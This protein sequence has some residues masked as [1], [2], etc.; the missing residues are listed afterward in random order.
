MPFGNTWVIY[1]GEHIAYA[2]TTLAREDS[3]P[4]VAKA[5][6]GYWILRG[7]SRRLGP[8][9]PYLFRNRRAMLLWLLLCR[10]WA[11]RWRSIEYMRLRHLSTVRN[12]QLSSIDKSYLYWVAIMDRPRLKCLFPT[13]AIVI[14]V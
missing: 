4:A 14:I 9:L 3:L 11:Y 6:P 13:R 12:L 7:A 8:W 5:N 2:L 10:I 1:A